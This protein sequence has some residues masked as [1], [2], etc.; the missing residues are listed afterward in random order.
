MLAGGLFGQLADGFF[1]GVAVFAGLFDGVGNGRYQR[2]LLFCQSKNSQVS[3]SSIPL[4]FI[5][6]KQAVNKN[7]EFLWPTVDGNGRIH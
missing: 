1:A 5:L 7:E 3:L 6:Q 2:F 4:L